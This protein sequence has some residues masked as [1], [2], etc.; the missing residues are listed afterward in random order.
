[1]RLKTEA[2]LHLILEVKGYEREEI[3]AQAAQKW[4]EAVNADGTYGRWA[5]ALAKKPSE[6]RQ[7]I[8]DAAKLIL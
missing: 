6:V 4:V 1:M 8:S 7:L 3:K 5:Y 2:P